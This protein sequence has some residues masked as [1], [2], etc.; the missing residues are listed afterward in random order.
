VT[1]I[2]I[3]ALPFLGA[4][5]PGLMIRSGRNACA[6]TTAMVTLTA[7]I[8]LLVH[9]PAV[10]RGE[11]IQYQLEW[12]PLLG[13]NVNFF[14]DGLGLL[15]AGLILGI[16][17]LI[18]IYARFYL[19]RQD[20]MGQFYTYL[21][22]FQGAMVGIVLSDNILLLLIFWE[23]TSLSSFLLIGYWKHLPEGRQG[24]RM[25]LA[26]TGM[27]GLALIGG[28]LIL[29]NIVGSYDLTVILQNKELVQASPLYL[30]ALIL[31]LLGCFTKSAQFPFHFWLP[32][33]MAAPTPVSAY[34]HS[35]T[36]VKAGLFLMA[37]LWP[38]LAGTPEW[39]YIVATTGLIT[40]VLG[41][42]IALFKDDLKALLAFSTVSHLGLITMLLGFGT[43]FAAVVA[44]FHIINHATFKAALFM[45]AGIVDHETHTRDIKR[46]GGLRHLMPVTFVIVTVAALSMAGIPFFN[47]FLSK[48]MMLD[49]ATMT[50]WMG[51]PWIIPAV[52]TVGALFSVAYSF[53]LI[54]HTF[55]GPK[56]DDYPAKPHDPGFGMWASP[57]LL[58]VLVVLIGIMPA[59][60]V[61]P[62]VAVASG[63]VIGGEL[64]YY[65]LKIWHG[66][67][68][69]LFLSIIAVAG[70]L[71]LLS[72]HRGLDA[73]WLRARR[74]EAKVI[75]DA[76]VGAITRASNAL[77]DNLHNG[78]MSRYAGVFILAVLAAGT[79]AWF[80]GTGAAATR[81]VTAVGPVPVVG[82]VL[83]IVAT[84][85][86]VAFHRNRL[87]ALVLMGIVGLMVSVGF[88]YMSAPDLAMTQISVEVATII[89]LLLALNFLP[90]TTPSESDGSRRLRDG[91]I[92][93]L[94]GLAVG[95]LTL[96][97]L[98]TDFSQDSISAFHLANSKP[99]GGGTNVV[100]VILVDFRGFDTF[101]EIIVLGIGA[102]VIFAMTESVLNSPVGAALK[103]RPITKDKAGDRH[104]LMMVIATRVMLPIALMV[105]VFIFLRGHNEPGGGFIAGLIVAIA[106]VMQYMAS[107][108]DWAAARQRFPY[109][110]TIALGVFAAALTGIGSWFADRPFLTSN[111]GYFQI[112]PMGEFE[113]ATAMAFDVG[114]F[115]CVVGAVMLALES[116]S[117]FAHR[118]G[119]RPS[120]YPM[121]I[122]PSRDAPQEAKD[123]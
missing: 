103:Q 104:P 20:P 16:G 55:L 74:P 102:L 114:V 41:A 21:L 91:F 82:W 48:E 33:A 93:A 79:A 18:I 44:V 34:L 31:I 86:M 80:G 15:F 58:A 90:K 75:F 87:L 98:L 96:A 62:L 7:L 23:L 5:L 117:R 94:G 37:R 65:S 50:P 113:L 46:L 11:V 13:L 2:L 12:M 22:L 57:A 10:L 67:N 76:V 45:S 1:L 32:H 70:G 92:A 52:A 60:M 54:I 68:T 63:A 99:G 38:V 115:L 6:W 120:P 35:A 29:G 8:G 84:G 111:Y 4:L 24:A 101:G 40:M 56:R 95:G 83:L 64:P 61:G 69:A 105:G 66:V 112:P 118:A 53:R 47:G 36:M 81:A 97:M 116:L 85:C 39:F 110:T 17:L 73:A 109:H 106:L 121:D 30:P 43:P 71:I 122:D 119:D 27:G 14:L 59:L 49:A 42:V 28:M 77:T 78:S 88:I 9:A 72:R 107:G 123:V 19:A 100:N 51:N 3:A 89:L 108:F 26:V 25:A